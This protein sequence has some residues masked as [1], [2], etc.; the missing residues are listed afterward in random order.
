MHFL[1]PHYDTE[2]PFG[3]P[4]KGCNSIETWTFCKRQ[5]ASF[6]GRFGHSLWNSQ[7]TNRGPIHCGLV[8]QG[9]LS[10]QEL[11]RKGLGQ[12][13]RERQAVLPLSSLS[14][15]TVVSWR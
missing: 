1:K 5:V 2:G 3:P 13:Q 9:A 7:T 10:A 12:R 15:P 8:V 11:S 14:L 6:R 4:M